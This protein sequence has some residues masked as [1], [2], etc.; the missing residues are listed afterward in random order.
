MIKSNIVVGKNT[1]QILA[2]RL[3]LIGLPDI[4]RIYH[5]WLISKIQNYCNPWDF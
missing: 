5:T 2:I 1:N 3:T 4:V